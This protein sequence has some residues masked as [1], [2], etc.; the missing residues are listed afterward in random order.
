MF[1]CCFNTIGTKFYN[2]D[3]IVSL[4]TLRYFKIKV[5]NNDIFRKTPNLREVWIP[6]TVKSH[7]Y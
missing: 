7:A 1:K 6:S 2:N 3:K 4:K 5:L